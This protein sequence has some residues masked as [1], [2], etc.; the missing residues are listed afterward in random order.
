MRLPLLDIVLEVLNGSMQQKREIKDV[1]T[2][3]EVERMKI[4][5]EE[6]KL[7]SFTDDRTMYVCRKSKR[8]YKL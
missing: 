8:I 7:A 3:T 4:K 5:E 1:Q 2:K 6:I